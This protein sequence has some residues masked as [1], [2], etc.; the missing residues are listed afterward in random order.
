MTMTS[1]GSTH[2]L[3]SSGLLRAPDMGGPSKTCPSP[4]GSDTCWGDGTL[5]LDSISIVSTLLPIVIVLKLDVSN[6]GIPDGWVWIGDSLILLLV[7]GCL[8]M[9]G[10]H[11]SIGSC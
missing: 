3:C 5:L 6:P 10:R 11:E 7:I 9:G 2:R 8:R 4:C 1:I